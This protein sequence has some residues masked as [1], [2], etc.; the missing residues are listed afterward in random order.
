MHSELNKNEDWHAVS[1]GKEGSKKTSNT[2]LTGQGKNKLFNNTK[3]VINDE[4]YIQKLKSVGLI[5]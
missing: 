2:S 4:R 5:F 3:I 1:V